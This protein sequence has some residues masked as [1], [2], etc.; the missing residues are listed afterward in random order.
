MVRAMFL[1]HDDTWMADHARKMK[2]S[3][4]TD[5]ADWAYISIVPPE[6]LQ[7][8]LAS[9]P[10]IDFPFDVVPSH[11]TGCG[12][13]IVPSTPLREVGPELEE[14]LS[15]HPTVYINTGTHATYTESQAIEMAGAVKYL[16]GRDRKN[17]KKIQVLWKLSKRGEYSIGTESNVRKALGAEFDEDQVR[18][19]EWIDPEPISILQS[20]HVVC[21]V[22]H[23]GAN[24]FFEALRY[25]SVHLGT[26][27]LPHIEN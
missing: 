6:G 8:L 22:N 1:N 25:V 3:I 11:I 24:S 23:G 7:V 10:E 16:L 13:I 19:T 17:D 18:I 9:R 15:R 21:S 20:G 2:E 27:F 26:Y 12:P 4:G 5:Y 14:W